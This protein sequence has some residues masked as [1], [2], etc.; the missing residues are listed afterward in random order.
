V[1]LGLW[2][3]SLMEGTVTDHLQNPDD[4]ISNALDS[5]RDDHADDDHAV[6]AIF[7]NRRVKRENGPPGDPYDLSWLFLCWAW[8]AGYRDW[9]QG[10]RVLARTLRGLERMGFIERR[11]I[12][13]AG[14]ATH[15]GFTV[16]DEGREA[17][18]ALSGDWIKRSER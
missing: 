8:E 11:T 10:L 1:S 17:V 12:R 9:S 3:P 6:E 13:C 16:T 14:H 15:H 2:V 5:E 7:I 18:T 4:P